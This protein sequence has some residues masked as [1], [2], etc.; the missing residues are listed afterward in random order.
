MLKTFL[1]SAFRSTARVFSGH[2]LR[3]RFPLVDRIYKRVNRGLVPRTAQVHGYTMYLD[4]DDSMGLALDGVYEARETELVSRLIRPG[5]VVLDLGANIGYYSLL[6][7]KLVGPNG[8]VFAFEPDPATFELLQRNIN[9]NHC[10]NVT[11]FPLAVSNASCGARLYRDRFNNLDHRVIQPEQ[12]CTIVEVEAVRLDE[13]LPGYLSGT[14]DF[15]K[16]DIQGAEGMALTGM[17]TLLTKPD[18]IML[19]TEYWPMGLEESGVGSEAFLRELHLMGF[20]VFDLQGGASSCGETIVH[21]LMRRY[22]KANPTHTN[23]LCIRGMGD[24]SDIRRLLGQLTT[25]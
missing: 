4:Q 18:R 17:R 7:A 10:S 1:F 23:L 16:M 3:D 25:R 19:L 20:R 21:D 22:P 2:G 12:E 5:F 9:E 11:A 8:H 6:F 15:V 13:F 24:D 14:I